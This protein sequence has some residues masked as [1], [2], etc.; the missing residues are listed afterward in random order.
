MSRWVT[1]FSCYPSISFPKIYGALVS[2]RM[3]LNRVKTPVVFSKKLSYLVIGT[4]V[5]KLR[6]SWA[7]TTRCCNH[8][9]TSAV[10][11]KKTAKPGRNSQESKIKLPTNES[12]SLLLRVRHTCAHIMAMAVQKLFP[13]AKVTIGPWI[14][15]GFYYDFSLP[16]SFTEEDLKKVEEEMRKIVKRKLP[17]VKEE[18]S[19]EEATK[20]IMEI[21]E[22]YKLEILDSIDTEPITIYRI[23]NEWWD[24]CA[25][26][27]VEHTGV[28]DPSS[29]RLESIAGAYWRGDEDREMLQ[30]IY[31]T[32]WLNKEQMEEYIRRK[33]EAKKRDH[34]V[35]G[36]Q[37]DL[38]SIQE[39]AGSGLV[40][41]H[42]KGALI[43]NL[44]EDSGKE[45]I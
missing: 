32:A 42:P 9:S 23:G 27:H 13:E 31:G 6:K 21:G 16:H 2:G 45:N 12:N 25:G 29:F 34:R 17:L 11:S 33:E 36:Q 3:K 5:E 44:I 26:P 28:I 10:S 40:F 24:L 1:S 39:E 20:R 15:N 14:E 8:S 30:R 43:R 7:F 22:P 4:K 37:L 38:F 41:W 35:I 19:R 18:V